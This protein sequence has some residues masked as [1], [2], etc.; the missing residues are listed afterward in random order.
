VAFD[1]SNR[2]YRELCRHVTSGEVGV[3]PF[4]GA[5]LSVY[6]DGHE[7]LPLWRELIDRL[8]AEGLDLGVVTP[9][10]EA[11]IDAA[12]DQGRYIEATDRVLGALG[13]PTF[14]RIVE[15]E[16]DDDGKDVPPGVTELVSIGWSL[17]V[18][19]NLDR[20]IARAYLE[21]HG[22]PISS[23]TNLDT[24]RLAA[25]MAGTLQSPETILAQIHG[26]L[27]V[28]PSWRLTQAHYAQLMQD[29]GYVQAIK[30]LFLRR[31]F[32][33]GFGLQ[34]GDIDLLFST[35]AEIYPAGV[36]EFYALLDRSRRDD[37]K[38]QTLIRVNGLRPIF[39]DVDE[40]S[41][42]D[43]PFHGHREA[44]ECLQ[45][46]AVRW[47]QAERPLATVWKYFPELDPNVIGVDD[48][49]DLLEAAL[50]AEHG[51]IVQ[52]LGVGGI[53]KTSLVQS[54]MARRSGGLSRAGF[55]F[56]F[57]CCMNQIGVGEL[58]QDLALATIGPAVAPLTELA[59]STSRFLRTNKSVV[60]LDGVETL[61][62]SD[63]ALANLF[64]QQI[65]EAVIDGGGRVVLTTRVP[66]RGAPYDDAVT[67]PL[68]PWSTTETRTFMRHW[69]LDELGARATS[70]LME[71]TGGHPLALRVVAGL[72]H[73]L[74][75]ADAIEVIERS[76]LVE[77]GDEADPNRRNRLFRAFESYEQLLTDRELAFLE[78]SSVFDEPVPFALVE[79]TLGR[80]YEDTSVNADLPGS[81]LRVVVTSLVA[82]RLV[83]ITA[84]GEISSHPTIRAHFG[85]RVSEGPS[86]LRP[87]HRHLAREYL[88]GAPPTP[89]AYSEARPLFAAARHAAACEDWS[90]F[91]DI[92]RRRLMR[93][94]RAHLTDQLGAWNDALELAM[95]TVEDSSYPVGDTPDPAYYGTI[96]ARS[97]KHLG[98][99]GDGRRWYV[100]SLRLGAPSGDPRFAEYVN[101]FLTLLVWRGELD[102]ADHM[103][104][105]NLRALSWTG[106]DWRFRWQLEHGCSSIAYLKLLQ[107]RLDQ[108]DE[109][110][111]ASDRAWDGYEG[112]RIWGW[113]HYL[114]HR[115]ELVLMLDPDGHD[116]ARAAIEVLLARA[117][118]HDWLEPTCRGLVH[119]AVVEID[120]ART[121]SRLAPLDE[122]ERL[123]GRAQGIAAGMAVPDVQVAF[124]L[125]VLKLM[126]VRSEVG[127]A[128]SIDI[129]AFEESVESLEAITG[130][131]DTSL[132]DAEVLAGRG[133]LCELKGA[134][135]DAGAM[136]AAATAEC[137]RSGHGLA[138]ASPRSLVWQL[139]TRLDQPTALVPSGSADPVLAMAGRPLTAE[140]A[141]TRLR[142]VDDT[143]V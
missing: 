116:D 37:P 4:V 109:L 58:I 141:T 124:H 80:R 78:S 51:G 30:Q 100:R 133:I 77:V 119:L 19:T 129:A 86:S 114:F 21:R 71:T 142:E 107:G 18:T 11:R 33:I 127:L 87:L 1:R 136:L 60:I 25:A 104:E 6:G 28:Y 126:C 96:I 54:L 138:L 43:D 88:R 113:D 115:G 120:R 68:E 41:G 140:W 83:D 53:G 81:D 122:A 52:V 24:H 23:V 75:E 8:V 118:E 36:G 85:E 112:D 130:A 56:A 10:I 76:S 50:V 63:R 98:R 132:A 13:E 39:Y 32:F 44:F 27:D 79:A 95:L 2:T 61:L 143:A 137:S 17:I 123:L 5:G 84:A 55:R 134:S 38:I 82:A 106:S 69:G 35:V 121:S 64:V 139:A 40:T 94:S 7:R 65:I 59:A 92:V 73:G 42:P 48:H 105:L 101:N 70:A 47:A 89:D 128:G 12:R 9:A 22:R 46:L 99:S 15:R 91:D 90:L 26:T 111:E 34:D 16:L 72:L 31:V 74:D 45:D 67:I 29:E 135:D 125:A 20:F 49:L 102:A 57:G 131:S 14:K 93:G 3:V 103:V 97:L 117:E 66:V 62:T 108:A 110:F